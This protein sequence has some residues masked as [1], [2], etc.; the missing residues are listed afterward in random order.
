MA[1]P[2]PLDASDPTEVGPYRL[3]GRLGDGGMGSVYLAR[4]GDDMDTTP[5]GDG[6]GPQPGLVAVKVIRADLARVPQF[7]ERFLRE[8]RAAQRVARFCTAEVLEVDTAGVRPYLV[9]E[10]I[11]GPTLAA[12]VR[13]RGP[14]PDAE[15]ERLA[16]AVVSALTAIHAAGIVHRDLKPGNIL[17]SPSGARV[18]DF[19]IARA[20][21]ATTML[22]E[23]SIGTPAF[24]AP[25]QALGEEV[26]P[27]ADVYAWGAVILYA[28]TGRPPYGD[29]PMPVILRRV[30]EAEPDLAAVPDG[31]RPLVARAMAKQSVD[32]PTAEELLLLL[33]RLHAAPRPAGGTA[34]RQCR[35]PHRTMRLR[36]H[37][38]RDR[39]PDQSRAERQHFPAR[40]SG[41]PRRT[42][43][44]PTQSP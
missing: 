25:E 7:R 41:P 28:A 39:T 30:V 4:R 37:R 42:S 6:S 26:T 29:G 31:L 19:G 15:L 11:D 21:D 16:V 22:T 3:L 20:M 36:P 13:A 5:P 9:T 24:M 17:L 23:G 27:A 1:G 44:S 2:A 40:P 34:G 38:R 10:Y 32:R 35:T 14:L 43:R 18:I 33:H 8:A 12:A